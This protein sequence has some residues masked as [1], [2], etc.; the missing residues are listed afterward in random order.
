MGV[1]TQYSES[2]WKNIG[3]GV[4]QNLVPTLSLPLQNCK[5]NYAHY[6]NVLKQVPTF[7]ISWLTYAW[8]PS[9]APGNRTTVFLYGEGI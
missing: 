1:F 6:W 9:S 3:P 8:A 5:R 7:L 2:K 4:R